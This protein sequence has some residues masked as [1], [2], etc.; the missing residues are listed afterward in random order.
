MADIVSREQRSKNMSAIRSKDTKP[1][2]YI[3]HLLFSHGYRYRK[4][5][6]SI[7]G[8]P[9]IYLA[10]YKTAIFI[11]GC[12]WHRHTNCKFAYTPKSRIEFWN[13]KFNSNISRDLVVH[14]QLF[15][16]NIKCL[17]IWE[18]CVKIM[19]KDTLYEENIMTAIEKFLRS[20]DMY[21]ELPE[22][23]D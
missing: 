4:N 2:I 13:K 7:T 1:E 15:D 9:D 3:R 20:S 16:E 19:K 11:N 21:M 22:K 17:V 8:C 18:C 10:K 6:S 12:F 14:H 23:S 5:C